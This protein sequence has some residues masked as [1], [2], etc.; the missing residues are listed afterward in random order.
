MS[1]ADSASPF[2]VANFRGKQKGTTKVVPP[3]AKARKP[4][5]PKP[6]ARSLKPA[7]R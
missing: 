3:F 4:E 2:R 1:W 5:S 7:T 6:E